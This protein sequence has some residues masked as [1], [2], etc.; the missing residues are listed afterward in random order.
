[1]PTITTTPV[2][3]TVGQ[4]GQKTHGGHYT[5][6]RAQPAF[7]PTASLELI[8]G[9]NPWRPYTPGH[10]FYV[11]VLAKTP[12]TIGAALEL[13]KGAGIKANDAQKHLRWLYTWG[14]SYIRVDGQVYSP[15]QAPVRML[16]PG[17]EFVPPLVPKTPKGKKSAKA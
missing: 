15:P 13:A 6:Y 4:Q 10:N 16:T 1:M 7:A 9:N 3:P 11:Q 5:A 12:A 14:G 8:S 17:G 2:A